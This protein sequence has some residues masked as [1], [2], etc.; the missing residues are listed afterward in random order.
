M[1]H[2]HA[3]CDYE[4][5][6]AVLF[7]DSENDTVTDEYLLDTGWTQV[8][9]NEGDDEERVEEVREFCS[10]ICASRWCAQETDAEARV[11]EQLPEVDG[12]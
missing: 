3:V 10:F 5:C 11:P 12:E 7:A 8:R 4:P 2:S 1:I 9:W 6:G